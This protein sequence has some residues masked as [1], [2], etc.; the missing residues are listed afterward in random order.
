M[1]RE[2]MQADGWPELVIG[3]PVIDVR[4]SQWLLSPESSSVKDSLEVE[5]AFRAVSLFRAGTPSELLGLM[6]VPSKLSAMPA[7]KVL[8]QCGRNA[9]LNPGG[10]QHSTMRIFDRDTLF[11]LFSKIGFMNRH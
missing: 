7:C 8:T 3:Q 4:I 6:S 5:A 9:T 2:A 10:S 11:Y 1:L